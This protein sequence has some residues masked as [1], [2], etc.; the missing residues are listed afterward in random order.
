MYY[1]RPFRLRSYPRCYL[2]VPITHASSVAMTVTQLIPVRYRIPEEEI[3]CVCVGYQQWTL[4]LGVKLVR[5]SSLETGS[6]VYAGR[7]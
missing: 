5:N 1:S 3:R 2:N 4:V 6:Y 7:P